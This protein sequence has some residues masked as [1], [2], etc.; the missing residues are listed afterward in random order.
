M[1]Y[2]LKDGRWT[3]SRAAT[4][5]VDGKVI[6]STQL[7]Q[8]QLS[9]ISFLPLPTFHFAIFRQSTFCLFGPPSLTYPF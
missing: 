3:Q 4:P 9:P 6:K 8:S 5:D 1:L 2:S 7:R